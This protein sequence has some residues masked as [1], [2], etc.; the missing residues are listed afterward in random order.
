MRTSEGRRASRG[1][2]V[3]TL[4]EEEEEEEEEEEK[5]DEEEKEEEW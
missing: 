2:F 3:R 1:A 5:E 4:F